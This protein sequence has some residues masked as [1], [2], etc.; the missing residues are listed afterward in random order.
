MAELQKSQIIKQTIKNLLEA[1]VITP[2]AQKSTLDILSRLC[3]RDLLVFLIESHQARENS[4]A[5][6]N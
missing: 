5:L 1:G 3:D 4:L 2:S 6:S